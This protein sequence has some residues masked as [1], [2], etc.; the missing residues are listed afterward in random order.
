[1]DNYSSKVPIELMPVIGTYVASI[2]GIIAV[3]LLIFARK[4]ASIKRP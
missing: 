1:M 4:T 3:I 2:S